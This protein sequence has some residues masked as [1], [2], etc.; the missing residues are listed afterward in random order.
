MRDITDWLWIWFHGSLATKG[1]VGEIGLGVAVSTLVDWR[2]V[3]EAAQRGGKRGESLIGGGVPSGAVGVSGVVE[4]QAAQRASKG[5]LDVFNVD[6]V[7][8][9]AWRGLLVLGVVQSLCDVP[10][11]NLLGGGW[12]RRRRRGR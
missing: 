11:D 12:P 7:E 10:P 3:A 9:F 2:G 4:T 1:S 8:E 5:Y 6:N